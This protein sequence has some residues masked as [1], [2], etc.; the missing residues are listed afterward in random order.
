MTRLFVFRSHRNSELDGRRERDRQLRTPL[1]IYL[2]SR[3][4]NG[5]IL[6]NINVVW[7]ERQ[8]RET[9]QFDA[10][11]AVTK[12]LSQVTLQDSSL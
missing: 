3:L 5:R 9:R 2:P 1:L 4:R 6:S 7:R 12:S 10:L 11:A 8:E